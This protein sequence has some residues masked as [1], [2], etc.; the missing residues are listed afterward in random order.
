MT[1]LDFQN[2]LRV[3]RVLPPV[4]QDGSQAELRGSRYGDAVVISRIQKMHPLA[5]QG[6]YFV[7]ANPTIATGIAY[8]AAPTAFSDTVAFLLIKNKETASNSKAKRIYLDYLK[9]VPTVIGAGP[10]TSV[11]L[12]VTIDDVN[13]YTAGGTLIAPVGVNMDDANLSIAQVY[14]G[15]PTIAAVGPNVRRPITTRIVKAA[16]AALLDEYLIQFGNVEGNNVIGAG[17]VKS[18]PAI[19][20]G[21]QQFAL[22]HIILPGQSAA[23]SFEF[24]LGH[25]EE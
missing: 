25:W 8:T 21:P 12:A 9:L 5:D 1:I 3:K 13:R 18:C 2:W 10:I 20:L 6:G 4:T 22:F 11:Q 19:I 16:V 7:S 14:A 23:S 15:T 24:E 17:A